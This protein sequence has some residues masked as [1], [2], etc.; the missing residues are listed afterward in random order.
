M[1]KVGFTGTKQGMTVEQKKN[2]LSKIDGILLIILIDFFPDMVV[3]YNILHEKIIFTLVLT[4][5]KSKIT[6]QDWNLKKEL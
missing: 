1:L 4:H 2:S 6:K 5:L 3:D